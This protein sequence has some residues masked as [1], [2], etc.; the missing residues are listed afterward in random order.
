MVAVGYGTDKN[1]IDFWVIQ[2]NNFENTIIYANN[3]ELI[4]EVLILFWYSHNLNIN[5]V[6]RNQCWGKKWGQAGYVLIKCGVNLYRIE[7]MA[8]VVNLS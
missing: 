6:V 1:G 4:K 5:K 2:I 7:E 8:C 3:D